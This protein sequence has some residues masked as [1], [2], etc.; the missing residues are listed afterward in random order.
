MRRRC[1][2]MGPDAVGCW[3]WQ[4]EDAGGGNLSPL[5]CLVE[6]VKLWKEGAR[7]GVLGARGR[8]WWWCAGVGRSAPRECG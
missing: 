1:D 4:L 5:V 7:T 8:R 6:A 3:S 2:G